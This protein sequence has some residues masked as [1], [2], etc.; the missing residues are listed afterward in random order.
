MMNKATMSSLIDMITDM[1]Q[2]QKKVEDALEITWNVYESY[3][4]EIEEIIL[5]SV[6]MPR[7]NTVEMCKLHGDLE[8]F[9]HE[10]TFCRDIAGNWFFDYSEGD[11]T[12]DQLINNVVNWKE[13]YNS[14]SK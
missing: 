8:G 3:I 7:D 4:S 9:G 10:D 1:K 5:D 12:K 2:K 6:G 13:I 14:Y 11:I